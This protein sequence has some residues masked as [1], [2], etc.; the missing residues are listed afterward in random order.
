MAH[1]RADGDRDLGA[2]RLRP[3]LDAAHRRRHA[4]G[5]D[6]RRDRRALRSR[7]ASVLLGQPVRIHGARSARVRCR[8]LFGR[9]RR[10][11]HR[12]DGLLQ[13]VLVQRQ[14][15]LP[16]RRRRVQR[17]QRVLRR[18]HLR[19]VHD[20]RAPWLVRR[21]RAAL[22]SRQRLPGRPLVRRRN[23]RH[24]R[25]RRP[26]VLPR[27]HVHQRQRVRLGNLPGPASVRRTRPT[28]LRLGL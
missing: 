6:P 13:H 12:A 26:T 22:L 21:P 17:P 15:M 7:R 8:L 3:W 16:A 10:A 23:V 9:T 24:L 19:R 27:R 28:L 5:R 11:L 20:L 25:R 2:R 4:H 1:R 18:D 14:P